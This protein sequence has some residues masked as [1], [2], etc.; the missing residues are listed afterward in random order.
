VRDPLVS[1]S[2]QGQRGVRA[3]LIHALMPI[4]W[5]SRRRSNSVGLTGANESDII[6]HVWGVACK[7]T[8]VKTEPCRP[9]AVHSED[10]EWRDQYGACRGVSLFVCLRGSRVRMWRQ[11]IDERVHPVYPLQSRRAGPA[12][13]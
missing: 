4:R 12:G 5:G 7:R 11:I 2:T 8:V 9:P 10:L 1:L 6:A 13:T 3:Q